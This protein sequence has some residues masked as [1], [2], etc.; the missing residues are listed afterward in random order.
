MANRFGS[1]L[2]PLIYLSDNWISL[3][4]VVLVTTSAVLW[5]LL[6]PVTA[7]V[8]VQNPYLGILLY[9]VLPGAFFL[10]LLLIPL[11]VV[12]K[13]R[14]LKARG[15]LERPV[16]V[17]FRSPAF[18]HVATFIGV[19]TF[20][21]LII[22]SQF[23][24]SA[25]NYMDS[26]T[27]CGETCHVV[28]QPEYTAYQNSPHSRVECVACHIGPGASWFVRS[29]LSGV[30]Q[31]FAVAFHTYSTPIP[32]P[33]TNLRPA[34]ETCEACHWP[35]RFTG[36]RLEII[37]SYADD[38]TNTRTETV[39]LMHIGGGFGR[40]IHG[41]HVG[42]GVTIR[43]ASDEARQNI[44]WVSYQRGSAAPV[45]YAAPGFKP[46]DLNRL[47][48][49]VMDCVDCHNRPTHTFELPERAVDEEMSRNG[50]S[51]RL[52]FAKKE[53]VAIL[54]A[55]YASR[56]DAASR[57]PAA[58][59][60]FYKQKYADVYAQR[61]AE[62]QRSAQTVLA[63]Y[64][65]NIFPAMK[66][67]W[68]TYPNNLGHMDFPGCFR[69]HDDSHKSAGGKTVPQDCNACHNILAVGEAAPKILTDLGYPSTA[70]IGD[71]QGGFAD[72]H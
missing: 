8:G 24:Y 49:R 60:A 46:D 39:L 61:Q 11:G 40:G 28:M 35:A 26:V 33:V 15:L 59:E 21:N 63:I 43:Y 53:S 37:P 13:R 16:S 22:G 5:F 56:A 32:T 66:V 18:R 29:K 65:R 4:G 6:L 44:P 72:A 64:D 45:A 70:V 20:A 9:L 7:G 47:T 30:R 36:D 3:I 34:R 10:S 25:V 69:C 52:P 48:T 50:I 51:A 42:A 12:R 67:T 2:A 31:V 55:S 41:V 1:W 71:P 58:F 23:T 68:G 19:T 27:F 62:V 17:D 38:A 54:K 14:R 57:L